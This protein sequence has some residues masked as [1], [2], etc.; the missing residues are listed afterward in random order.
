VTQGRTVKRERLLQR[1]PMG[2]VCAEIGVW[3]GDFSDKIIEVT[4]PSVLCLIDPWKYESDEVYRD[5]CYGGR[6]AK[7]QEQM[8]AVYSRVAKRFATQ[9]RDGTVVIHRS[10]SSDAVAAFPDGY[11]DWVYI[12]GNHLYEFVKL[13]LELWSPKIKRRGYITGDDYVEGRW[14]K[15]GV[16]RAVDEFASRINCVPIIIGKQ[17]ILEMP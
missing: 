9:V 2:G 17:F 10:P 3:E 5:A 13:D 11:F 1:M 4:K 7:N 15:G 16:K 14:W 8:D 12:D 6:K